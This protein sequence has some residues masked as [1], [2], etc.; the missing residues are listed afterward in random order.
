MVLVPL[1]TWSQAVATAVS[2]DL[3]AEL[4][5]SVPM[6]GIIQGWLLL[7]LVLFTTICVVAVCFLCWGRV[8]IWK[9]VRCWVGLL[10]VVTG[11]RSFIKGLIALVDGGEWT[12]YG[13][14]FCPW[15]VV[16]YK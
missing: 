6:M 11:V 9:T 8:P 7:Q 1:G 4:L 13:G 16:S 10:G 2:L 5:S 15:Q 12:A 3:A 14:F